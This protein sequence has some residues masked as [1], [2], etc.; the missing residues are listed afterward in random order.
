MA[1]G[2]RGGTG[3]RR[4]EVA[5]IFFPSLL[6]PLFAHQHGSVAHLPY[7]PR[8]TPRREIQPARG[9]N[10]PDEADDDDRGGVFTS[11]VPGNPSPH[12]PS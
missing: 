12:P 7:P 11:R 8:L 3:A 4:C 5:R 9:P 10:E 6:F 2:E 1:R